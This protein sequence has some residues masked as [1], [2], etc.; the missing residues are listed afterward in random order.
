M[1]LG[2]L[3]HQPSIHESVWVAENAVITANVI[4]EENSSVWY[5]AVIRGDVNQIKIGKSVNVQDAAIIHG[6]HGGQDTIVGDFVTIGHRAII[7]GCTINSHALIG[8]GAIILDGAQIPSYCI[9][10]AGAL[11]PQNKVLEPLSIY[12][13]IPA[14]KI[15][16]LSEAEMKQIIIPSAEG[17]ARLAKVYSRSND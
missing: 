8:M 11:V 17:Y 15:K 4:I 6:S 1:I 10:G 13:G 16:S 12:A 5:H 2:L 9:V 14:V 3:G 7:H